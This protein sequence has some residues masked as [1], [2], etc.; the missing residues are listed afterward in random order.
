VAVS[1]ERTAVTGTRG[2]IPMQIPLRITFRDMPTS[3]SV[4]AQVRERAAALERFHPNITACHVVV[5][6]HHR[7]Q[8]QGRLYHVA[9]HLVLPEGEI[10][11]TRDPAAHH[12]HEDALVA[13]RDAFEAVERRLEDRVRR[14]RGVVKRHEPAIYGTVTRLYPDHGFLRS[15]SDGQEIYFHRNSVVGAKFGEL[16]PGAEVRFALHEGEGAEGEQAS[17]VIATKKHHPTP[18]AP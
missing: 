11:V 2:F 16:A 6:A 14:R 13:V 18:S 9:V 3:Q 7:H 4:D 12:A 17:T 1:L 15:A 5:E 10:A 8:R